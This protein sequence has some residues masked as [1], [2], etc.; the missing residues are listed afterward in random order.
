MIPVKAIHKTV[1]LTDDY[2]IE[3][4]FD[5]VKPGMIFEIPA[6]IN[7]SISRTE[8]DHYPEEWLFKVSH[9]SRKDRT[10]AFSSGDK[11]VFDTPDP[12]ESSDF[13]SKHLK[14]W[15]TVTLGFCSFRDNHDYI[16]FQFQK[17]SS[18]PLMNALRW[19]CGI[20]DD[21]ATFYKSADLMKMLYQSEEE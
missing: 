7:D 17:Q 13:L 5:I 20:C 18:L 1:E 19:N 8:K 16:C 4:V 14:D 11:L 3:S 2:A 9:V 10:I 21:A 6:V 15:G 12:K